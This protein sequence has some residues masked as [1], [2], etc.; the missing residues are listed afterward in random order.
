M[1][2]IDLGRST[3]SRHYDLQKGDSLV[4]GTRV[5]RFPPGREYHYNV[6]GR[7]TTDLSDSVKIHQVPDSTQKHQ[8]GEYIPTIVTFEFTQRGDYVIEMVR[9]DMAHEFSTTSFTITVHVTGKK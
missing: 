7:D 8:D 4:L 5:F 1:P 9:V 6:K 3:E 2:Q